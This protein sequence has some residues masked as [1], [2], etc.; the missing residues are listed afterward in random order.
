[1]KLTKPQLNKFWR[2]FDSA[3]RFQTDG[4][5]EARDKYRHEIILKTTG[6]K[7]LT[8][9]NRCGEYERL[10]G[11]L[12]IDAGDY[13]E[14]SRWAVSEERRT[15]FMISACARQIGEIDG[16]P[17]GWEYCRRIFAQARLP[18]DWAD[19]PG[20]K[21]ESVF[22]MLDTHRRRLLKRSWGERDPE[23]HPLKFVSN[24]TY[25]WSGPFLQ[26]NAID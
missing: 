21:L 12:A 17:K 11:E 6:R 22:M 13:A 24:R 25:F 19:I 2:L 3:S 26:F 20:D 23:K 7:S 16:V 8:E 15:K 18:E 5:P 4:T 9:V 1:M 14:A 10:M